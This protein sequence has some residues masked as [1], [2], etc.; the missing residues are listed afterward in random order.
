MVLK[1]LVSTVVLRHETRG[2]RSHSAHILAGAALQTTRTYFSEDY[3]GP[4]IGWCDC[5]Q[6]NVR[7]HYMS[8]M[9]GF[10][11]HSTRAVGSI[12]KQSRVK[13]KIFLLNSGC[14]ALCACDWWCVDM[15]ASM[16]SCGSTVSA[17]SA[18][19]LLILREDDII[20]QNKTSVS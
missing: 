19:K 17:Q 14:V 3:L 1:S 6:M 2:M 15:I 11:S 7:Y 20:H 12:T 4:Q 9:P 16:Q 13:E 10:S 5:G 8:D 18:N